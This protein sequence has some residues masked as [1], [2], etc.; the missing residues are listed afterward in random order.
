MACAKTVESL[1]VVATSPLHH[2][3]SLPFSRPNTPYRAQPRRQMNKENVMADEDRPIEAI[4]A[5][6]SKE[7][8]SKNMKKCDPN[9]FSYADFLRQISNESE[10]KNGGGDALDNVAD[11]RFDTDA[12]SEP[13]FTFVALNTNGNLGMLF[14]AV[15]KEL[16]RRGGWKRLKSGAS[17]Y[18]MILG[19]AQA[20]GIPYGRFSQ[21]FRY[22][23][24]ITPMCN[25]YN[26]FHWLCRKVPMVQTLRNYCS[27]AGASS[28]NMDA[29]VPESFIFFPSAPEQSQVDA[30]R[31]AYESSTKR[32]DT[33]HNAW[34]MKPSDGCK[35]HNIQVRDNLDDILSWL[36]V[37]P[38]G[39]I[40]YVVQRYI[41]RPLLLH[42]GRKFD[43]RW[44]VLLDHEYNVYL[45]R[46]GVCRTS[47]VA[48]N[49]DDLEDR[50]VHL[51][52]H[53]VQEEHP[54]YGIYEPTNE[55]F[56]AEFSKWLS[57]EHGDG[58]P[59]FAEKIV[60]QVKMIIR[61]TL[62]A[63]KEKMFTV[64]HADYRAFNVFGYDFLVDEDLGVW[65]L[66]VNS[67]PAV[68]EELLPEFTKD[69]IELAIDPIYP[70][71][72]AK[73]KR[74]KSCNANANENR[75]ELILEGD[76]GEMSSS[77]SSSKK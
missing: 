49:M 76:A 9:T 70:V 43:M 77:S 62:L 5:G 21:C 10:G 74:A 63:A 51:S 3:S 6:P 8:V 37:Q 48:F 35:G 19:E 14:Q 40:S 46:D 23:Y 30:F 67:S 60:P 66:E 41:E 68:A 4:G 25:F 64:E 22:D 26:G 2:A 47:S 65:L 34:I 44:W 15:A 56:F 71:P 28:F 69:L 7:S 32:G 13:D 17:R 75:F 11:S 59:V 73:M 16:S 58:G 27:G 18:N 1:D 53:C 39:S 24:G 52:N 61:E 54:D 45:Y 72:E 12:A 50:F 31:E 42:G 38:K 33:Q 29:H 57:S 36:E 55:M 20:K